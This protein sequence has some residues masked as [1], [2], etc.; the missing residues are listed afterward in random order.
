MIADEINRSSSAP[1]SNLRVD[2]LSVNS[3]NTVCDPSLSLSGSGSGSGSGLKSN[4]WN[5]WAPPSSNSK[6]LNVN[7]NQNLNQNQ[8]LFTSNST[9]LKQTWD[10]SQSEPSTLAPATTFR[11]A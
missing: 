4:N 2:D 3:E 9:L 1:P 10:P 5:L 7:Q 6:E 11:P 8:T